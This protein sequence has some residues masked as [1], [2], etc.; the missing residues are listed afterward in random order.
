[1]I[2]LKYQEMQNDNSRMYSKLSKGVSA[3]QLRRRLRAIFA[4]SHARVRFGKR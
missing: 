1:M 4:F 2:P 3:P